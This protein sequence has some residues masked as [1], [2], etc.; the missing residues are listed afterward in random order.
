MSNN[1]KLVLDMSTYSMTQV[2]NL[3]GISAHTLRIWERRYSFLNPERTKTNIRF[4]SDDEVIKLL[5]V[6]ILVRNGHRISKID[7]MTESERV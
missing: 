6:A 4:Y 3:T 1:L 7:A 2:E 5:N